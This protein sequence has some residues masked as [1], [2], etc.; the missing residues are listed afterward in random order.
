VYG[1]KRAGAALAAALGLD[2]TSA[3]LEADSQ[4]LRDRFDRTFWCDELSTYVLALDRDKRAC[5]VQS[6]NAG[7]C[8]FTGVVRTERAERLV[9]TLF[10]RQSFAGWGIRTIPTT[11]SCYNP[12][13]YHTGTIWPH[14]NA[15]IALGLARYGFGRKAV[16][17]LTGLFEA[18]LH[19]DLHRVPELFCG[20]EQVPGEGPILYPLPC[21]PQ[22]W[23]AASIF[24]MVQACLGIDIDVTEP[25]VHFVR[26]H[27][28]DF[29]QELRIHNLEVGEGVVDLLFV[30]HEEDVSVTVLRR[31]GDLKVVVIK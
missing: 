1:A 14:D 23:S 24:L 27:L 11:E 2:K 18:S 21:S 6:S 30:R 13:G 31:E 7:Q 12:M 16:E 15:L 29:P 4:A 9:R 20:F 3:Q 5:C 25:K 28:P 17:L 19:F 8:L 10:N 22:A 26:P